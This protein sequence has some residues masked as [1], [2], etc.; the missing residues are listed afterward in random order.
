MGIKS[1]FGNKP[2]TRKKAYDEQVLWPVF[3]LYIRLRDSD[4][5]GIG[6]CFTC[7]RPKHYKDADCGHGIPRQHKATKYNE[8]NNH[9]QCKP[10]N[11]FQGG[12]REK[13]KEAMDRKYGAGTWDK[14]L[15]A[16]KGIS[17]LGKTEIDIMAAHYKKEGQRLL[18]EKKLL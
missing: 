10:C 16:S 8:T 6:R 12:M 1:Q 2:K 3:S 7:G 17:K 4:K 15:I 5:D 18:A 11:G 9:L 14:M 13:Y